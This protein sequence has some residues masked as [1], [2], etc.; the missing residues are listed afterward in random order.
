MSSKIEKEKL[1][2]ISR[3]SKVIYPIKEEDLGSKWNIRKRNKKE[4]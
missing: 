1:K 4:T 2:I 3:G